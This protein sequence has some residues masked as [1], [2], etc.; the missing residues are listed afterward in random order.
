M[1]LMSVQ[2]DAQQISVAISEVIGVDVVVV[3]DQLRRVAD[4]FHYPDNVIPIRSSSIIGRIIETGQPI[5]VD[6]KHYYQS[7]VDCKDRALCSMT[8][9]R[10]RING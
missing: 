5:V 1:D 6:N 4:T 2:R 7:C 8:G 10:G 3:D 9:I